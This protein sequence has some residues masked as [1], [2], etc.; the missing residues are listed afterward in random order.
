MHVRMNII[1]P[2]ARRGLGAVS[3]SCP[4]SGRPTL[5]Q[6]LVLSIRLNSTPPSDNALPAS[7]VPSPPKSFGNRTAESTLE[8]SLP[9]LSSP[10]THV[11]PISASLS[12]LGGNTTF[13]TARYAQMLQAEGFTAAQSDAVLAL[14]TEAVS[15]SMENV[16][17]SMVTKSEQTAELTDAE[18]DFTQL[19]S[20][21]HTLE[22]RDFA[23]LRAELERILQEVDRMKSSMREEVSRVHGGVRLDINLEKAR[24]QDEA[25]QLRDMVVKAE[26]RI[27]KEMESLTNR[28]V[29]IRE[30]TKASLKQFMGIAFTAFLVYK[31]ISYQQQ[32]KNR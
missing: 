17:R 22:K 4:R 19:R 15:E 2:C 10:S 13:N 21:I 16:A 18:S 28:M 20:E 26:E 31:L 30:G 14:V 27:D 11:D 3:R 29:Q 25:G 32:Q 12:M 9:P 7:E 1:G 24:I 8:S 23:I 5:S 6:S